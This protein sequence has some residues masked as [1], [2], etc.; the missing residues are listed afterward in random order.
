MGPVPF[1]GML[2]G[3]MGADVL[4]ID[5]VVS[6]GGIE[7]DEKFDLR[8]RNKRSA[9]INLKCPEGRSIFMQL[10][11]TADILLEGYRPGVAERLGIG[12][13]DCHRV[14]P[15]LIYGR[16]TG[17]GQEGPLA[18][19][20]GHDLNYIALTGALDMMGQ[21]GGPPIPPLN[22]VGDYG[23]GALYLAFWSNVRFA[24][25][26]RQRSRS[27]GRRGYGRRSYESTDRIPRI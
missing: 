13:A 18:H 5:R 1:C 15:Q 23:G 6:G 20:A 24:R 17:W 21:R 2:L 9:R 27:G 12:P 16:G 11:E 3:D 14:R 22:L 26:P 10:V 4:R 8:G 25:V 19:T 7:L